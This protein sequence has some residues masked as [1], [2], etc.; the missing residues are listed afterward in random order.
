MT[1]GTRASR[2]GS[3]GRKRG[4]TRF[5]ISIRLVRSLLMM[6]LLAP[7]YGRRDLSEL[8]LRTMLLWMVMVAVLGIAGLT[9]WTSWVAKMA[10]TLIFR[11]VIWVAC[12]SYG[13]PCGVAD[14]IVI[15]LVVVGCRFVLTYFRSS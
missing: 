14:V 3:T 15:H 13:C 12:S 5:G 8:M 10:T 2:V 11:C 6:R 4:L 9:A 1:K 7:S